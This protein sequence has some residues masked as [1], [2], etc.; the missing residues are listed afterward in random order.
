MS[1][2]HENF[3]KA[4]AAFAAAR[5]ELTEFHVELRE[6]RAA[7]FKR[8]GGCPRCRG[9]GWVVVWD[10]M[11]SMSGC[12]AEY[13][14]CPDAETNPNAHGP[15]AP[16]D[17]SYQSKYDR[18]R[19]VKVEQTLTEAEAATLASLKSAETEAGKAVEVAREAGTPTRG[20]QVRVFKGRKVAIGTEGRV[21]WY[22]R[23][24]YGHGHRVGFETAEGEKHFT[25]E[26]NVEVL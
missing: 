2:F 9:R 10:T 19:G 7:E 17:H 15:G 16:F 3:K 13:G 11:D 8:A 23:C 12:Y 22:G 21:F 26:T 20:K 4:S 14:P 5:S 24:K 6:K 25:A 1:N 18:N